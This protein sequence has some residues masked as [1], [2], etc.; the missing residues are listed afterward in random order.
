MG[1]KRRGKIAGKQKVYVHSYV[2]DGQVLKIYIITTIIIVIQ[3]YFFPFFL[4]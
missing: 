3:S 4:V 2:Y 1:R